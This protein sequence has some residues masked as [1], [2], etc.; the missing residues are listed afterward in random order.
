MAEQVVYLI[1][2]VTGKTIYIKSGL[3][4]ESVTVTVIMPVM[5]GPP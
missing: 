5:R 2:R 3:L 1:A 4:C